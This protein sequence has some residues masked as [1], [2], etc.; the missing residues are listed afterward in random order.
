M[1]VTRVIAAAT[2]AGFN[3][4]QV[5][6]FV[7]GLLDGLVQDNNMDAI[8]PCLGDAEGLQVELTEAVAD[9][10]KKDIADII[11][12]VSVVGK[13]IGTIDDDLKDC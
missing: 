4:Q 6:E 12:G 5:L 13:M 11:K 10:A 2:V 8:K 1:S 9:F 7:T 3:N